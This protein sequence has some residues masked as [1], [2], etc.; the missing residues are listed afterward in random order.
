MWVDADRCLENIKAQRGLVMA[1]KVMIELVE[2]G[3]PRDEA[4]EILG[5]HL[6]KRLI[7]KSS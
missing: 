2:H 7:K 1:E 6:L 5:Q 4:H 3:I